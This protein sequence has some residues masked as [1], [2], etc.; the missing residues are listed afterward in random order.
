MANEI[1]IK[2]PDIGGAN[3]VDVIEV[4]V[5][6]GDQ[7][8]IDTPLITLESDKASMEIPSTSAGVVSKIKVKVGDKVSEGD[9]IILATSEEKSQVEAPKETKPVEQ[10]TQAVEEAPK[11][12][13][14]TGATQLGA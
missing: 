8:E 10:E 6:V 13:K 2:V 7:I 5:K 9:V 14:N 3:K 1:E 12:S 11:Q 4:L